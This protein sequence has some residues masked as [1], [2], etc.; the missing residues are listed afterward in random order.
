MVFPSINQ[1][2][3]VYPTFEEHDPKTL[4]KSVG[5]NLIGNQLAFNLVTLIN[6]TNIHNLVLFNTK[7]EI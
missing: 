2:I 5:M 1:L 3:R 6:Q 7:K 4:V